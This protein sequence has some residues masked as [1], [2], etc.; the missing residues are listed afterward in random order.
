MRACADTPHRSAHVGGGR[1]EPGRRAHCR[2]RLRGAADLHEERGPMARDAA[3]SGGRDGVCL[4]TCHLAAA[5]YAIVSPEGYVRRDR[6]AAGSI[7]TST[8]DSGAWASSPSDG[9]S[10]T[11]GSRACRCS[12]RRSNPAD[13]DG[14]A[15]SSPARWISGISKCRA[16]VRPPSRR[17]P[18]ARSRSRSSRRLRR[19]RRRFPAPGSTAD[20][21]PSG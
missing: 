14:R 3:G 4:D 13:R 2:A 15:R 8:S 19:G 6:A 10:T 18:P 1:R 12:S 17:S 11:G 5:G 16:M 21:T 9:C 7:G 20:R